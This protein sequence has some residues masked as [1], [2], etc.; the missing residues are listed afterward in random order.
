MKSTAQIT[1]LLVAV[2]VTLLTACS[3]RDK[4]VGVGDDDPEMAAAIAKAR[5]TLPQFWQVFDKREHGETNFVLVVRIT[6]KGHIEHF[7]V[8]DFERR[9]G[10]TMVTINNAPKIVASVKLGDRIEI[11][12]ADITDWSYMRD[13]KYVGMITFKARFKH[14]RAADVEQ[15]RKMMA[16]P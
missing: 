2:L 14:M 5:Q 10:K 8:T 12:E 3:K 6:D 13:G 4:V 9:D 1:L 16:D 15:A 11:P 7:S